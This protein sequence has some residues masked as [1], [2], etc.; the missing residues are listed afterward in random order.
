ML[1]VYST[2]LRIPTLLYT[3]EIQ[4][5]G[6]LSLLLIDQTRSWAPANNMMLQLYA[7]SYVPLA[8]YKTPPEV[9]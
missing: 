5:W 3:Q 7:T 4:P 6:W 8:S 9:S 2:P 1:S